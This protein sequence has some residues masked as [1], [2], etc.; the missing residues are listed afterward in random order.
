MKL[1][2]THVPQVAPKKGFWA[3][4]KALGPSMSQSANASSKQEPFKP[5]AC[6]CACPQAQAPA[7]SLTTL[8]S[9]LS[10]LLWTSTN[11]DLGGL[12]RFGVFTCLGADGG[13]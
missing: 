2:E 3:S 9:I 8:G 1:H 7:L 11:E 5:L 4:R 12:L 10:A 6:T 13:W